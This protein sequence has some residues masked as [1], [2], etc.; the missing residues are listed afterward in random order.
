MNEIRL[1]LLTVQDI[2]IKMTELEP[3]QYTSKEM[4]LDQ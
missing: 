4:S 2:F 3:K 1:G